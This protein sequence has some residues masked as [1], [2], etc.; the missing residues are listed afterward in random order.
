MKR[1]SLNILAFGMIFLL[2]I[3]CHHAC[4]A[5]LNLDIDWATFRYDE[6]HTMLEIYYA[7]LQNDIQYRFENDSYVGITVGE[8]RIYQGGNFLTQYA[9]KNQNIVPDS[10]QL[11]NLRLI[12]DRVGFEF[13]PGDY[14]CEFILHDAFDST[15]AQKI[16]WPLNIPSYDNSRP[17]LSDLEIASSITQADPTNESPFHKRGLNVVPNPTL[18]FSS[19]SPALFFYCEAY[20][21]DKYKFPDGYVLAYSIM[22]LDGNILNSPVPRRFTKTEIMNLSVEFGM[23]NVGRLKSGSYQLNVSLTKPDNSVIAEKVKKF[24]I[25]QQGEE[26][27][28]ATYDSVGQLQSSIFYMMDSTA[29]SNE[30]AIA[31]Y[32]LTDD[33][34]SIW[35]SLEN[36]EGRKRFLFQFWQMKDS[37]PSTPMNEFRQDYFKRVD[38]ANRNYRAFTKQGWSTDRGRVYILYGPPSDIERHP[39]EPNLYP[40]EIWEYDH[41]QSGVI[42]V[43]GDFEGYKNFRLLHSNLDGE[44]K[45]YYYMDSLKKG[46]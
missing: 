19:E 1:K 6:T 22:D 29:I 46:Y 37:D 4:L 26:P 41:I 34:R 11:Q 15:N 12:I 5:Q 25:Y 9:W 39:N 14:E 43:F 23:M 28:A 24:Y 42:F 40:Y 35:S 36:L 2:S 27:V 20:N 16:R 13:L 18:I 10:L 21:L 17:Y 33:L 32:L 7:F 44:I 8:L 45:D 30:F 31:N 38:Y 3:F